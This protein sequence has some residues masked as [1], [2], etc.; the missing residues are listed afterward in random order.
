MTNN[1]KSN[2]TIIGGTR[3]L[4]RWFAEHLKNDF[5]IRITSRDESSGKPVAE[6]IG[7]EYS[8]NNIE[9]INDA[10]I[11]VFSVPIEHMVETIKEVAPHAPEGSLLMDVTSVKT[12]PAEALEKY[13]P[14][15]A[16]ILPCHPMFG[17]RVPTLQRQIIILTPIENRS[18]NWLPRVKDYLDKTECEVVITTP[19]EHDKYMSI[20]QGLTHFSYISLASTIR[21]LNINVK[22]SRNFSSPVYTIMLDM[23]SRIV[24]QNP[25]LYYSIQKNN[26]ETSNAREALIKESIYL[27]NLIEEGRE[28]D[29]VN[30][31]VE[32]A[33][34][35]DGHEDALARSDKAISMLTQKSNVLS[36]SIGK[37]V[38][39]KHQH[40]ENVHMGIVKE[41]GS[42]SVIL[43][44]GGNDEICFKLSN[45][46][47]MSENEI[48]EW[49]KDN[50][51]LEHFNLSVLLPSKCD[52]KH[53]LEMFKN[54]EP[55]IDVE[56][57]DVYDGEQIDDSQK[58]YTFHYTLFKREDKDYVE[59]FIEGIGGTIR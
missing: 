11:I 26:L 33:K 49:K 13:A 36:K 43:E 55:V 41:V 50:L 12:E 21:K 52:E 19:N 22:E 48:F 38:G 14:K 2:M 30:S 40:S 28:D 37:E 59:E 9:A 57:V 10:D 56:I 29:F 4:G 42:K 32:S 16:E 18:P 20:V 8:N 15:N 25:Y 6:E 53:L 34:H 46:D 1:D 24:Y 7:V 35:L 54:I 27:S 47:I 58:S 39:L 3:G 5:N 51:Q 17:P 31:V 44:T 23:V 45:V